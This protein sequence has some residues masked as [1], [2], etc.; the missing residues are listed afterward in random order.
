L[1]VDVVQQLMEL[2]RPI[3]DIDVALG[4]LVERFIELRDDPRLRLGALDPETPAAVAHRQRGHTRLL[5]VERR[6]CAVEIEG[7]HERVQHAHA[8]GQAARSSLCL[9]RD[10]VEAARNR[11]RRTVP[12]HASVLACA[13]AHGPG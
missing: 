12:V 11:V 1:V 13:P 2:G 7:V 9:L 8:G 6:T 5:C 4:N 3:P 10:A